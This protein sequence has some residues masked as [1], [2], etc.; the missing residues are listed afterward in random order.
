MIPIGWNGRVQKILDCSV[1]GLYARGPKIANFL[2]NEAPQSTPLDTLE[3]MQLESCQNTVLD[4]EK[5]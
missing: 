1:S 3:Q 5:I 4:L 2:K